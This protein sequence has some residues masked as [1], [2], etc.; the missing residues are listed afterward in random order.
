MRPETGI[1]FII[2]LFAYSFLMQFNTALAQ[3]ESKDIKDVYLAWKNDTLKKPEVKLDVGK[4][5]ISLLPFVGYAPAN[6][7]VAGGAMSYSKLF[8]FPPTSLSSGMLNF[9]VTSKKQ[10]IIN[11][12]SIIF[13]DENKWFL[14]GDWRLLFFAQP[15]YGLGI[16]NSV[17][18]KT[19][20]HIN[21][22]NESENT[23]GEPMKYNQ[24]RLYQDVGCKLGT[25]DFYAGI[26]IA[27][28]RHF[29]IV[30]ELLDTIPGSEGYYITKH[31]EYSVRNNF[32]PA[33]Y[34]AQGIKLTLFTDTRDNKS[35]SFKGYYASVSLLQ[36]IKLGENSKSSLQLLYDARYYYGLSR[37]NPRHVLAFWSLGTF[38]LNESLPYLALP[39]IGWDTY[40]RSGRG[41][42]QGRYR[43][44]SMVYNEAEY[45]FPI[46]GN[47][48]F[49]GTLFINTTTAS[50]DTQKLFDYLATGFG[51]GLRLQI[52]KLARTNLGVDFGMGSDGSSGIYF[53]LQETF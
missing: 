39:S 38:L 5:Y 23:S 12:R 21:Q 17:N 36:N 4:S 18:N 47:G 6:G 50:S 11:A 42:I 8:G 31:Y 53:N 25:S 29:D 16:D 35:N 3:A 44:L 43:G 14:Q 1:R 7:F 24:V 32:N 28:D 34:G 20:F 45:R 2:Y 52:D 30:D 22:L 40:N 49:G 33:H 9:V 19:T 46:T 37:K 26:G 51:A 10:L 48:L 27:I 13:L 15:T 41:F